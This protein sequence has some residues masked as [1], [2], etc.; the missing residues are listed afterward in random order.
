MTRLVTTIG[1]AHPNFFKI[2]FTSSW[3]V[4]IQAIA[5]F[6]SRD[7]VDWKI[8]KSDWS[9][10]FRSISQEPDFFQAWDLYRNT[11]NNLNFHYRPNPE[12]EWLI[13]SVAPKIVMLFQNFDKKPKWSNSKKTSG[14]SDGRRVDTSYFIQPLPL[15][16][17]Q[18][19]EQGVSLSSRQQKMKTLNR[20]SQKL[21]K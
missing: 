12:K 20:I 14:R 16:T 10:A 19:A 7:K 11:V 4:K 13:F 5:S 1:T 2:N 8:L 3:T 9:R 6:C 15:G 18:R 21:K 17:F